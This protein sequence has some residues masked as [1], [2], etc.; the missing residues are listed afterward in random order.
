MINGVQIITIQALN[1]TDLENNSIDHVNDSKL[2]ENLPTCQEKFSSDGDYFTNGRVS[3]HER[4][5]K[6][7]EAPVKLHGLPG[8]V[9]G[10]RSS[11][12]D[13]IELLISIVRKNDSND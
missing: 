2:R 7:L 8:K 10:M 12:H 6:L 4:S 13:C 11:E 5:G 3:Q 1:S 9:L